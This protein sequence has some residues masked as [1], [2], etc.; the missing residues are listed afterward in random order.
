MRMCSKHF[1]TSNK[2]A[3]QELPCLESTLLDTAPTSEMTPL[4]EPPHPNAM[5]LQ[6]LLRL[7]RHRSMHLL[8]KSSFGN[9]TVPRTSLSKNDTASRTS[10][11]RNK[12]APGFESKLFFIPSRLEMK[13]QGQQNCSSS[14]R[15]HSR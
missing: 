3:A 8:D 10:L 12:F 11:F 13:P 14:L 2:Y 15:Q 9:D 4:H 5:P 1:L 6:A 7:K